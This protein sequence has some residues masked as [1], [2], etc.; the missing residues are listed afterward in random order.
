MPQ[1][2]N[3]ATFKLAHPDGIFLGAEVNA[4]NQRGPTCGYFA[5]ALVHQY[6]RDRGETAVA[7]PAR[8]NGGDGESLRHI[9]M[10]VVGSSGVGP[11]F[12]A[13][14]MAAVS[15]QA[16]ISDSVALHRPDP[17]EYVETIRYAVNMGVPA[18]VSLAAGPGGD[19]IEDSGPRAHWAVVIGMY[20]D[21]E[22]VHFVA[23]HWGKYYD[24][25]ASVLFASTAGLTTYPQH[26]WGKVK[27]NG[28][29][30]YAPGDWKMLSV[31]SGL[32][33]P[34]GPPAVNT[35]EELL[36]TSYFTSKELVLHEVA[37][38][39]KGRR[40]FTGMTATRNAEAKFILQPTTSLAGL[41][42]HIVLVKPM[43]WI[44]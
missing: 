17:A 37:P 31:L 42:S 1:I 14:E 32:L 44:D 28:A 33:H 30:P 41:A 5:L 6:W 13:E 12:Q 26:W 34:V 40:V 29:Y 35:P 18:I 3:I 9:G 23:T 7:I 25:L 27:I 15:R 20:T 11:I 22:A 4:V 38:D 43:T 8:K 21:G 39:A 24:W 36:A 16:G 10:T 2:A 19:P